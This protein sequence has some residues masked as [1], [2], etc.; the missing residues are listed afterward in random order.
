MNVQVAALVGFTLG[1]LLTNVSWV[2]WDRR[3]L[4]ESRAYREQRERGQS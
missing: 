4:R 2:L 3:M 1:S